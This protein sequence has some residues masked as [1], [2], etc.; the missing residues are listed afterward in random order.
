M[1]NQVTIELEQPSDIK[2]G[3]SVKLTGKDGSKTETEISVLERT[4]PKSGF[5]VSVSNLDNPKAY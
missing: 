4:E 2:E 1:A 5:S 3:T